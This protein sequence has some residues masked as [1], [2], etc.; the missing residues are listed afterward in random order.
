MRR[1]LVKPAAML[2]PQ[3][4]STVALFVGFHERDEDIGDDDGV[5]WKVTRYQCFWLSLISMFLYS[6]FP[7]YIAP[8]LQSISILCYITNQADLR[9]LSTAI[10][11]PNGRGGVGLGSI[12]LD[13][14]QLGGGFLTSPW[15][16]QV[17]FMVGNIIWGWILTPILF[18][19]NA[20]GMDQSL[21]IHNQTV[22]NTG[23]LFNR[24]GVFVNAVSLY[25]K[26][27]FDLDERAYASQSPIY[28]TSFFALSYGARFMSIAA[29]FSHVYIWHGSDIS[30][31]FKS[32]LRQLD[33]SID[34]LDIH[35]RLMRKYPDIPEWKYLVFL[36]V[37]T[38]CQIIVSLT[39]PF[40]MP[41]WA[42]LLC[43]GMAMASVLP[44]GV[45]SAI[46]GTTLGLNVLTEFII[47]LLIPGKT[48]AVMTFKSLGTNSVIQA[49]NLL[50]DLKLGHYMKINPIHMVFAQ[51]CCLAH[52]YIYVCDL[53]QI[54]TQ[55]YGTF[56]GAICNTAASFYVMDNMRS[57]LGTA[58]WGVS[59]Y[60]IFYNA[61]AI[62]GAIGPQR[63]F[64]IGSVYESLLWCFLV[65]FALPFVPWALNKVYPSKNWH[66]V[67]VPL[68]AS[69]VG[70]G[71]IQVFC[72]SN[73][74]KLTHPLSESR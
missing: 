36:V 46:S 54:H 7:L 32:A 38:A 39:T 57:L 64:G 24:D 42:V 2:W 29:A 9:F 3:C 69:C 66:L 55:L 65:G 52:V 63:F 53:M 16:A 11:P 5:K 41:I 18:Y 25:N 50:S 19:S 68:L 44:I 14:S 21:K 4:L 10:P 34:G 15:W 60:S 6:W 31:Q 43:I 33:D 35:N 51:V 27:T 48:I 1:F 74:C 40:S 62:W 61:G 59:D 49:L 47:G 70:P 8:A 23:S 56:L 12:T 30:R 26:T 67:N 37:C 20:F 13:W 72:F 73:M 45:I 17:N 22:L 71:R 58:D 28:I